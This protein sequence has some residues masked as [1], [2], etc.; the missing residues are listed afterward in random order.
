VIFRLIEASP[1]PNSLAITRSAITAGRNFLT[2]PGHAAWFSPYGQTALASEV[3]EA[4]WRE[5]PGRLFCVIVA[6]VAI[7]IVFTH[8]GPVRK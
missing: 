5:A 8:L 2:Q 3:D 4:L 6:S 7:M 1:Q